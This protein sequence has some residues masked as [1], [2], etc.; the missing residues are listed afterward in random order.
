MEAV[1]DEPDDWPLIEPCE[2]VSLP[3]VFVEAEPFGAVAVPLA[4]ACVP[5]VEALPETVPDSG[6]PVSFEADRVDLFPLLQPNTNAAASANPYANFIE[7][8]PRE[9]FVRR[10][11]S[12][13]P[14]CCAGNSRPPR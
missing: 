4:F 1:A 5:A 13:A 9:G 11:H 14:Q 8:P 2:F 10:F 6:V 12:G 7:V 3:V